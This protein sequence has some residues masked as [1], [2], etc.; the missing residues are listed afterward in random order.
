MKKAAKILLIGS[1]TAFALSLSGPGG[2]FM[3]GFLK[4]L[5]AL[6]FG[7]FFV[8]NLV[9]GEYAK[10]DQEQKLKQPARRKASSTKSTRKAT[11]RFDE[12]GL[13]AV[14]K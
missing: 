7:A 12:A 4:P 10:Y 8:T 13:L 11:D 3:W 1:V 6:L 5:G 9:A 2:E 14:A